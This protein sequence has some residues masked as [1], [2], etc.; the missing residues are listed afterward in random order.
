MK[1]GADGE[2]GR[3]NAAAFTD[4]KSASDLVAATRQH[5][6]ARGIPV[7]DDEIEALLGNQ[8][9]EICERQIDGSHRSQSVPSRLRHQTATK[10]REL[11]KVL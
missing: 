6:L 7:R 11:M 9:V 10:V 4:R 2:P 3:A 8:S 1:R 5:S